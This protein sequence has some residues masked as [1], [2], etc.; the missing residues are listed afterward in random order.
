M[1]NNDK[2]VLALLACVVYTIVIN[3]INMKGE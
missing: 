3:I 1:L 2:L